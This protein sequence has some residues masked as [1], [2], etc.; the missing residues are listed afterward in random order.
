MAGVHIKVPGACRRVSCRPPVCRRPARIPV[1][2][3][4]D[5]GTKAACLSER[6]RT[7]KGTLQ[8]CGTQADGRRHGG[9]RPEFLYAPLWQPK[10][11]FSLFGMVR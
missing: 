3:V 2:G 4:K 6:K 7:L 1:R 11:C 8:G 5:A 10:A 9:M